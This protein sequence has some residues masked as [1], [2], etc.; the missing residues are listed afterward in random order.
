MAPTPSANLE[1]ASNG[2]EPALVGRTIGER[3]QV[4]EAIGHGRTG[5]VYKALQSQ[6][7]RFVALKVLAPG[8]Q[9]DPA[10]DKRF[11]QEAALTAQLVSPHTVKL[12]DHGRTEDGSFFIAMEFLEG[13]TLAHLLQQEGPLPQERAL[14]IAKQICRSLREAHALGIVHR[15]LKPANIMLVEREGDPFFVKVL[16]IGLVKFFSGQSAQGDVAGASAFMESANYIAPEQSRNQGPDQRCDVYALGALLYHMLA[17]RTPFLARNP[18]EIVSKHLRET[19]LPLR[20][21]NPAIDPVLD[22]VVLRCLAK[23]PAGRFESMDELLTQLENVRPR[24]SSSPALARTA[25]APAPKPAGRTLP[26]PAAPTPTFAIPA[27]P[28]KQAAATVAVEIATATANST[29]TSTAATTST[30]PPKPKPAPPPRVVRAVS[31]PPERTDPAHD[32]GR[33]RSKKVEQALAH[34]LDDGSQRRSTIRVAVAAAAVLAIGGAAVFALWHRGR[35]QQR[36]SVRHVEVTDAR[37]L[38][39]PLPTAVAAPSKP[40]APAKP[41]AP[42]VQALSVVQAA[43]A[44]VTTVT[45]ISEPPGAEVDDR[46]GR[47][48]GI[49]PLDLRVTS[50]KPLEI[51]FKHDG[52][53]PLP[54]TRSRVSGDRAAVSARLKPTH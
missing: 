22:G 12:Y 48:L 14:H 19:P 5:R 43:S 32:T 10:F 24:A 7:D 28:K 44:G 51:I 21:M 13:H 17:G 15:S 31:L 9:R 18:V 26:T 3:Y 54:L 46:D 25:P 52:Y 1:A 16:D 33:I 2:A 38:A 30:Q 50:G 6:P 41:V 11:F 53:E 37:Q 40:A 49:T 35:N 23:D 4:I 36:E 29:T 27:A 39:T 47:P 8:Q 20:Q 34:A 42:I 45:L